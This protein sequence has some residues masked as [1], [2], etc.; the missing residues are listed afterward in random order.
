M[1]TSSF[2][3][4]LVVFALV[5]SSFTMIYLTQP[6]LPILQQE[7]SIDVLTVSFTVSAVILGMAL[8][9]LPFGYIADHYPVQPI[10][11]VGSVLVATAALVCMLTESISIFIGAR[12]VQGLFIPALTTCLV[13]YLAKNLPYERLNVVMGSYVSATVVG[14]LGGRLLGGWIHEPLHWRYAFL[15]A[16]VFVIVSALLAIY[17][18][19]KASKEPHSNKQS[20]GYSS[21]LKQW[22]MLRIFFTAASGFF[23][24]SSIF[25][26]LPF[27]LHNAPFQLTTTQTTSL[28]L[29][30]VMGIFMAPIAGKISN[31]YGHG[32]TMLSGVS[33]LAGSLLLLLTPY[34]IT[35]FIGLLATCSGFFALHAAAVGSLNQKVT[36]GQGQANALYVLF[37]YLGGWIGITVSGMVFQAFGWTMVMVLCLLI[38]LIPFSLVMQ[39]RQ[40]SLNVH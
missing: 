16:S 8:S 2:R 21:I 5:S 30:Y 29:V 14:G 9:N 11:L 18:L 38:L 37:Y 19:P 13:A 31:R 10:I 12:F 15:S 6:I 3:L 24:F 25:N 33:I 35:V 32:T 34:V 4:Q 22:P 36:S 26:Y 39:E 1:N 7:F 17:T 23:V 40:H 27:R 28:Y 20:V